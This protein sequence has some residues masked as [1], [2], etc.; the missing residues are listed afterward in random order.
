MRTW[1]KWAD[2]GEV[3]YTFDSF[4]L[5]G[6]SP[7]AVIMTAAPPRA[8]EQLIDNGLPTTGVGDSAGYIYDGRF[9]GAVLI[10]AVLTGGAVFRARRRGW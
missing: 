4:S 2:P 7:A 6:Q 9:W 3:Q 10:L 1:N 5:V 8:G